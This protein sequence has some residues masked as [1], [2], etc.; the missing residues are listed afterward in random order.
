MIKESLKA[1]IF[2]IISIILPCVTLLV[3]GIYFFTFMA[4]VGMPYNNYTLHEMIFV[5]HIPNAGVW[6]I[7][8]SF[9]G[10]VS[11]I[12]SIRKKEP[13]NSLAMLALVINLL[14]LFPSWLL[15]EL[16]LSQTVG[17]S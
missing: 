9:A 1:S 5:L 7:L 10:V 14:F 17:S 12:I 2:A 13:W 3:W 16:L 8:L 4:V 15:L 6:G 11:G